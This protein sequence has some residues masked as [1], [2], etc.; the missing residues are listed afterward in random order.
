MLGRL[1]AHNPCGLTGVL[2][3]SLVF[4]PDL[5]CHYMSLQTGATNSGIAMTRK[6]KKKGRSG[7]P[8]QVYFPD[9]QRDRLRRIAKERRL[10]ESEVV[11]AAVE[12][13]MAR[14]SSGQLELGL[15]TAEE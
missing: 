6:T 13:F 7:K 5:W 14:M 10:P 8:L 15:K 9:E 2:K 1:F 3:P 12:V 11:R 4:E